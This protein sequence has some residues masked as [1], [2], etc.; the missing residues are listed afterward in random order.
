MVISSLKCETGS[1]PRKVSPYGLRFRTQGEGKFEV[2]PRL[3]CITM[4]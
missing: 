4:G 3:L 2:Y 1:I